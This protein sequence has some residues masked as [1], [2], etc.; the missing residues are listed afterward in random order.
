[1]RDIHR[2]REIFRVPNIFRERNG[3][4]A[5]ATEAADSLVLMRQ[6][7]PGERRPPAPLSTESDH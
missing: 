5:D 3:K 4:L 2:E 7:D 1:V 6:L